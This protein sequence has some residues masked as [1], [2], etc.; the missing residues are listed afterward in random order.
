MLYY[1]NRLNPKD[2]SMMSWY[3]CDGKRNAYE[4]T[5]QKRKALKNS[6]YCHCCN[7]YK[8]LFTSK[9]HADNYIR[10]NSEAILSETGKA[11]IRSYYCSIC[12]GWH[13]TSMPLEFS[14]E[15]K[16]LFE[17]RFE[18]WYNELE[19]KNKLKSKKKQNLSEE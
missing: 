7:K 12:G 13:L 6:V 8:M 4:Y 5:N 18:R 9:Q 16:S 1:N 19:E 14:E 3:G 15:H 10:F 2:S 11:P 17:V